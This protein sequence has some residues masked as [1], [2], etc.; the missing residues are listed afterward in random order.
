MKRKYTLWMIAACVLISTAVASCQREEAEPQPGPGMAMGTARITDSVYYA[1]DHMMAYNYVYP[2]TDPYGEPVMLSGTITMG[3][4]VGRQSAAPALVLYNHFT[5]YRADQCPTRGDLTVQKV[6]ARS[7]MITVSADYYGFGVTEHEHQAYCISA[8]NA[9]A[10]VDALLA[11]RE[12][13]AAMGYRWEDRLFN[14]GYSQGGQTS[15]GVVRLVA[16]RYPDL[17]ITCTMAGAGSYDIPATYSRFLVDTVAG[18]PSTVIS[19]LL[20]YN[21]YFG[22]GARRDEVFIEPVLSHIDE[23]VLSKR[24]TRE[25]IDSLVGSLRVSD[26]VTPTMLDTSSALSQRFLGAMQTDNLCQGWSPRGD[27]RIVLFHNTQDI[28]VPVENTENMY[29][30]LTAHGV[31]NVT[32]DV[33]DYGSSAALP[34][35]ESGAL[36]FIVHTRDLVC[37]IL[38][39][40]PW[41]IM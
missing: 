29:R 35:H 28:T 24:Y 33:A 38:G 27:E 26:Y 9:Q 19:V 23:W 5:V 34:A 14:V 41:S 21:E 25:Q 8:V 2:S 6:L 11:A 4:G 16:E 39:I 10:S 36:Y 1:A 17:D 13:L 22:L 15:M 18:M 31:S 30:Y 7:P 40:E 3:D 32:L 37:D 20:S 12:L